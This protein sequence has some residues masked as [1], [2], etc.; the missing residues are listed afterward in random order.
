M[1]HLNAIS[2]SNSLKPKNCNNI[3]N[4]L[5]L[6][7][8]NVTCTVGKYIDK[9]IS[10]F[11]LINGVGGNTASVASKPWFQEAFFKL[12]VAWESLQEDPEK[13]QYSVLCVD[14]LDP[15]KHL[16]LSSAKNILG[17]S[18][19]W[20]IPKLGSL[21]HLQTTTYPSPVLL[22]PSPPRGLWAS[23]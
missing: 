13:P 19:S 4:I 22:V 12:Q 8:E 9:V 11:C 20:F 18:R 10:F 16:G 1:E 15:T 14:N 23:N 7:K 2:F 6:E 17:N 3:F 5:L 21:T